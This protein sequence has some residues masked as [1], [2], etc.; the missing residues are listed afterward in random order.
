MAGSY[1]G[2]MFKKPTRGDSILYSSK[3][4]LRIR[5]QAYSPSASSNLP[6]T[7]AALATAHVSALGTVDRWQWVDAQ[8]AL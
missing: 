6:A 3:P 1:T 2:V 7:L 4:I 8:D 5:G